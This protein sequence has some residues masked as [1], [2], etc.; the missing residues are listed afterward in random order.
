MKWRR[1]RVCLKIHF[2]RRKK[3]LSI[4]FY[5]L[6]IDTQT[7]ILV[8]YF[9]VFFFFFSFLLF[10]LFCASFSIFIIRHNY[11]RWYYYRG[12][13]NYIHFS[14]LNRLNLSMDFTSTDIFFFFISDHLFLS[15]FVLCRVGFFLLFFCLFSYGIN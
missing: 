14:F 8:R 15:L 6:S 4:L 10:F 2:N 11:Q 1:N 13:F 7:N 5:L 12:N 9:V 3:K